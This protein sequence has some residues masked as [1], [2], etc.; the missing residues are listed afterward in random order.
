MKKLFGCGQSIELA[1][2]LVAVDGEIAQVFDHFDLGKNGRADGVPKS[3]RVNKRAQ[4]VLIGKFQSS[5]VFVKPMN[6]KL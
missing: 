2:R 4:V 5:V 3:R 6:G 1:H